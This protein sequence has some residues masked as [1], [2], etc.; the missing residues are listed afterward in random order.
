MNLTDL[1]RQLS[2]LI[3]L[4]AVLL[5]AIAAAVIV[6]VRDWRIV[7][8]AY[9]ALTTVLALLLSQIIPTEWAL[10]QAIVGGLIAVMLYCAGIRPV[11]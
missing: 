4:P 3:G 7:L 6:I 1:F 10:L 8:F 9:A 2:I 5:A 11:G